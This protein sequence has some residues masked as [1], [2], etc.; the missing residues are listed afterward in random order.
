MQTINNGNRRAIL[1]DCRLKE[2]CDE[3]NIK[4]GVLAKRVGVSTRSLTLWS[5]GC[6]ISMDYAL[7]IARELNLPV[8]AIWQLRKE[9]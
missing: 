5:K 8:E 6:G 3:R 1:L 7:R 2:I 4:F 9:Q